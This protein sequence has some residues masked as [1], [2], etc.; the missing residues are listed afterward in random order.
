MKS[1]Y[2]MALYE[3][4]E[5][6]RNL[7]RCV[8]TFMV[9]RFRELLGVKADTYKLGPDFQRFV[10]DPAVLEV[11]GLS[12]LGVKIQLDR[13]HSRAPIHAVTMAWWRKSAEEMAAAIQ[14]RNRSKVGRMAR[15]RGAVET[16]TPHIALSLP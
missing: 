10:V 1:K 6:R 16:A 3:M 13:K 11:N 4:L 2:A 14:E 5:L 9:D 8:E 7:D 15:L 12:D